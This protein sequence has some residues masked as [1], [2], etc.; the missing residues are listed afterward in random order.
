VNSIKTTVFSKSNKLDIN[1]HFSTVTQIEVQYIL[2][3]NVSLRHLFCFEWNFS[4]T[5]HCNS[6]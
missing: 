3:Y 4:I 5:K 2:I 6:K 1:I